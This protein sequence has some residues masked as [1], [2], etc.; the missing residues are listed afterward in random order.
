MNYYTAAILTACGLLA[1]CSS[2]PTPNQI[3]AGIQGAQAALA[4]YQDGHGAV[5]AL[6]SDWAVKADAALAVAATDPACQKAV[7]AVVAVVPTK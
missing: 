1:A 3:A 5:V 7:A 2:K 6:P 4:C